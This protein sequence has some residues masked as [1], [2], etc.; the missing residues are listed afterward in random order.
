MMVNP[1]Y[2]RKTKGELA[3]QQREIVSRL[4]DIELKYLGRYSMAL[5]VGIDLTG[6]FEGFDVFILIHDISGFTGNIDSL[7]NHVCSIG[8]MDH[9]NKTITKGDVLDIIFNHEGRI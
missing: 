4:I 1:L 8:L 2:I 7:K 9:S 6:F 5:S 3:L